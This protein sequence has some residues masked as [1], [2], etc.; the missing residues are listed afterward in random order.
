MWIRFWTVWFNIACA[1]HLEEELDGSETL[2]TI[3]DSQLAFTRESS[4]VPLEA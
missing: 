2:S 3:F 4:L 1:L